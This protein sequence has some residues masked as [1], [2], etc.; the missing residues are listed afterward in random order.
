[1]C[2]IEATL[3]DNA[4]CHSGPCV[5][6]SLPDYACCQAASDAAYL[7]AEHDPLCDIHTVPVGTPGRVQ[8][9]DCDPFGELAAMYDDAFN[10]DRHTCPECGVQVDQP[11]AL[12]G[13]CSEW[14]ESQA[15]P[16]LAA[17]RGY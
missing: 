3:P 2:D 14:Y 1:M 17:G 8:Q 13:V 4:P 10:V 15:T 12:C 5:V 16:L 7:A 11:D 9:C 6:S